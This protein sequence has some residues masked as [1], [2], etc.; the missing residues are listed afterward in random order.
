M[1]W[2]LP[3]TAPCPPG[4]GAGERI[5]AQEGEN[6][7]GIFSVPRLE[8]EGVIEKNNQEQWLLNNGN[9]LGWYSQCSSISLY[10]C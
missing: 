5:Q 8:T 9:K 6:Q 7:S 1:G 4:K 3:G 2:E 10:K